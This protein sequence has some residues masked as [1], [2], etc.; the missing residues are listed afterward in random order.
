MSKKVARSLILDWIVHVFV[1]GTNCILLFSLSSLAI[2]QHLLHE[3][4][5]TKLQP[6]LFKNK[7]R[8]FGCYLGCGFSAR[9][10]IVC[11]LLRKW[12][13]SQGHPWILKTQMIDMCT[14]FEDRRAQNIEPRHFKCFIGLLNAK[15]IGMFTICNSTFTLAQYRIVSMSLGHALANQIY[16][17]LY[18]SC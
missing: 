5:N 1:A 12:P 2:A 13:S 4:P 16:P 9:S 3:W 17:S 6:Q 11:S 14:W 15:R 8:C 18:F 7:T 10:G